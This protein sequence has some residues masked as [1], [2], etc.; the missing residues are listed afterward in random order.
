MTFRVIGDVIEFDGQPLA[1]ITSP[2]NGNRVD[3]IDAL[4]SAEWLTQ[5]DAE[6]MLVELRADVIRIIKTGWTNEQET[7]VRAAF[8]QSVHKWI[9]DR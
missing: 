2:L 3:A 5:G 6:N 8:T 1:V 7:A 9:R 4:N